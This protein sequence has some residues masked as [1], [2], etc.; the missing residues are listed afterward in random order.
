MLRPFAFLGMYQ[1]MLDVIV[2]ESP[3]GAGDGILDRLELLSDIDPDWRPH[4]PRR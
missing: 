2:D 4:R 3:L 1:A